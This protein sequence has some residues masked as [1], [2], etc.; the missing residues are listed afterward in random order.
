MYADGRVVAVMDWEMV[1]LGNAVSD[2]GWWLFL[3]RFHTDGT[4]VPLPGGMLTRDE[5]IAL[6]EDRVGRRAE[7]VDF[8]EVVAGFHF[9]LVMM[10]IVGMFKELDPQSYTRAVTSTTGV[11]VDGRTVG[12]RSA[13]AEQV[14]TAWPRSNSLG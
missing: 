14:T 1:S 10:R 13:G 7:H 12:H 6:W 2:L 5:S 11:D 9:T 8:Y 3:Q 4:G